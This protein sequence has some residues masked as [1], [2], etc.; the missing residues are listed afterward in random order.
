MDTPEGRGCSLTLVVQGK[1]NLSS[2]G[3]IQL[4]IEL[5]LTPIF[6]YRGK[7]MKG[8]CYT[9]DQKSQKEKKRESLSTQLKVIE[10][11]EKKRKKESLIKLDFF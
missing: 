5:S 11:K 7:D 3:E 8:N 9:R 4:R 1:S 6:F 2:A 10:R